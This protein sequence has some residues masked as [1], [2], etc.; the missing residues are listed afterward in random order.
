MKT[1]VML[2]LA[3]VSA[4]AWAGP[5]SGPQPN[6]DWAAPGKARPPLKVGVILPPRVRT[7]QWPLKDARTLFTDEEIRT[8]R[9][10]VAKYPAAKQVAA[11]LLK[12]AD[13]WAAWSDAD[14]RDFVATAEVPRDAEVSPAG[15][16][17]HGKRI[18]EETGKFY[19]WI[20][21][22]RQPFKVK[23]PIGGEV[24][25]SN[26][27]G[28]FYRSGFK[29][30]R[31]FNGPYVDDG[32]GWLAPNG[33]RYWFVA[34]ANHW[35]W[36]IHDTS[37]HPSIRTGLAA[38]GRAYLLTGDRRYAHTAAVLL[39][40]VAEVYPNMDYESQSRYGQMMAE[41][42]GSRYTGKAVNAIWETY[43][44]AQYAETYDA[45]WETIDGDM[46]L[47]KFLGKDGRSIRAFIEANLLEDSIDA[48]YEK[49]SRGN[50]GMHQRALAMLA[51]VRQHGDNRRFLADLLDR[52]EGSS[53]LG[54][55]PAL[56]SLVLRDGEPYE[57]PG[58]NLLWVQ[59][60]TALVG[61]LPKLGVDV[62]TLPRLRR[63]YD[64]PL[65]AIAIGRHTPAIGDTTSIYG[66]V[67]GEDATVY[68]Q[69][70]R[71]YHD[72][73]Y[74][75]FLA[76]FGAAG[77]KGFR[78]FYSLLHP[79]VA[80]AAAPATP[81]PDARRVPPQPS[82]LLSGFGLAILNDAADETAV[83][84]YFGQHVNHA[85]FDRLHFDLF[86]HGWPM[87]P[88]LGYPDAMNVFVAGVW[89]W[90]VNT[91]AHNTVTVDASA[92]PANVPGRV[93]LMVDG[94][95]ARGLEVSALGTYPQCSDYRRGLVMVEHGTDR[96][97][98][99]FFNVA[100]GREH[101]YSLHGPAGTA[102]LAGGGWSAPA[103]GTL[104]GAN[105]KLGEIYDNPQ[106]AAD[107]EKN[108]YYEYRGSGFQHI[109]NVRQRAAGDAVVDYVHD[110]DPRAALRI[111]TLAAPDVTL[112]AADARVSPVKNPALLKFI[113]ARH[114]A[115]GGA[116]LRSEFV[117]V[118]EPNT[119]GEPLIAAV[120]RVASTSG[121]A[122]LVTHANGDR[123]V[124]I[125]DVAGAAKQ[126]TADGHAVATTARLA[127]V[128]FGADGRLDRVFFGGGGRLTVDGRE[129]VAPA[130]ISGPVTGVDLQHS[131]LRIRTSV[132][133]EGL[134][135][136]IVG[137]ANPQARTAHTIK[138]A[139]RDGDDLV[140]ETQ[141]DLIAGFLHLTG[142]Q[143]TRLDT[144]MRLPFAASYV[145]ATVLD[146]RYGLI[147]RVAA[148]DQDHL[149]LAAP[150]AA[151]AGLVGQ[152]AWISSVGAGD[153][154]EVPAVFSWQR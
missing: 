106:M 111:R 35:M 46:A 39:H 18:F 134:A 109:F 62:S 135:G 64:A 76:A 50:Y 60:L 126:L 141:D 48:I 29:D 152:D 40:R 144:R 102:T 22:P 101:D 119:S 53:Y 17:I 133:A 120:A 28:R 130:G 71:T 89:T 117:S 95:W 7:P 128:R 90:S 142:V 67:V 37:P 92:Q 108:G 13:Y 55:R 87:M 86:A 138:S 85:H 107:G 1:S 11:D 20:I 136:R 12:E 36:T 33:Q 116:P 103:P 83:S 66:G 26:D 24:Y 69:A 104:A 54:L 125:H 93:E 115:Q 100:G 123:D 150:P 72:P 88:D 49:R 122:L 97:V 96:Y 16:P 42:D 5:L 3:G 56:Y 73:R 99:D 80:A 6:D 110:K 149:D 52:P 121:S 131:T 58:Y 147:G 98:V 41:I 9:E 77:E 151:G 38:L 94:G 105:V 63:L 75:Q 74:A 114:V 82:R 154:A 32:R 140:V 8:A 81:A 78:D 132:P 23:C 34:Y 61:L 153:V 19:P 148:A 25:P 139:H 137:F 2:L 10:N 4:T 91:I 59:N 129:F 57:S 45:V 21:D 145:G 146:S 43:Q 113:I 27:Y 15:C 112:M 30:R 79:P 118:I 70:F 47:Q 124:V 65:A 84:L 14:L 68:Q 51:I 143:G 127:V 31:D 44:G